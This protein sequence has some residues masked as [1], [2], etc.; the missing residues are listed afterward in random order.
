MQ[1]KTEAKGES[2]LKKVDISN[3]LVYILFIIVIT[4]FALWLGTTFFSETNILNIVR[5]TT[6]ISIMAIAMTFVIG[7]G[8]IDLSIGSIAG[9][10]GL[11]TA[12]ILESTGSIL[13][14]VFSGIILGAG[15]GLINGLFVTVVGIPA[16]LVTLGMMGIIRGFAMWVTGTVPV[17][18]HNATYTFLFGLGTV[19]VIPTLLLWTIFFLIIGCIALYFLP[20]GRQVLAIGGNKLSAK[21]TGVKVGLI[22]TLTFVFS[23]AAAAF[24]GIL[25]TGRLQSARWTFGDGD[26]LSVIAAVILGGTALSGGSGNIVGAVVGAL[27]IGTINNG[28]IIGGLTVS[29]QMI[30]RG[31]IIILVVSLGAIGKKRMGG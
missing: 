17:P 30:I 4:I 16:F 3:Y 26:E 27:L 7:G 11:I 10:V 22:T 9:L 5:Q 28:L 23:G 6:M 21:Y 13:L 1:F 15:I 18:I 31:A 8:N 29:Q 19:G 20:Y 14:S 24:A 2:L 12:L 25:Y